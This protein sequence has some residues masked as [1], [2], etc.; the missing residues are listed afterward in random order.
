[1]EVLWAPGTRN[2]VERAN[3]F[4]AVFE[5]VSSTLHEK[6]G[7]QR[8]RVPT[9]GQMEEWT[10][11][12]IEH[13]RKAGLPKLL[14]AGVRRIYLANHFENNMNVYGLFN[15]CCNVDFK[16]A[17]SV[18]ADKLKAL[19][20]DARAGGAIIEMWNNTA[21][22]NVVVLLD[23]C[24]PKS[25]RI[26]PL[27]RQDSIMEAINRDTGFVRNPSNAVEAD[28]YTP[29]FAVLNLRDK[30]VHDYFLRRWQEAHD[31]VGIQGVFLDSSFNM[32]SDKFH[33]VQ[34]SQSHVGGATADNVGLLGNYRP[35]KEPPA[36]ILTQY[37]AHLEIVAAMQKM[38]VS[39]CNEDLGVFGIHRHGPHITTRLDNL[40]MWP[41]CIV[42]F[43][44]RAIKQAGRDPDDI[45]IRG[46]S[47]RQMW[48]VYW[49]VPTDDITYNYSG[50]RDDSDRPTPWHL[51]LLRAY[52][53]VEPDMIERTILPNEIG[54]LYRSGKKWVVWA[55]G[56]LALPVRGEGR[57][58]LTGQAIADSA[59][60]RKVGRGVYAGSES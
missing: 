32:S 2:D 11:A 37:H 21:L 3:D 10:P 31:H 47:Y 30:A 55:F 34:N 48:N 23:G 4:E 27:P 17:E 51:D 40:F 41:D 26:K 18:G 28:H 45:F 35:A 53:E 57:D 39:Y 8:E 7:L 54:V 43:D 60:P 13:Y 5:L 29:L 9:Y 56:D 6:A 19:C 58:V 14:K 15:F 24:D 1:M 16:I 12:D 42:G 25:N 20:D 49:H 52:T 36:A 50:A 22:S 38:G 33:Y 46:L 44:A 59:S